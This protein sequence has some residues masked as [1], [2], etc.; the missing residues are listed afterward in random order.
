MLVNKRI[1]VTIRMAVAV[2]GKRINDPRCSAP[3]KLL[4]CK[5]HIIKV[6][7]DKKAI[8]SVNIFGLSESILERSP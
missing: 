6:P 3:S 8:N 2:T 5:A 4:L 7:K 1:F